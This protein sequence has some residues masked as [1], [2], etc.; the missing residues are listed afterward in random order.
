[1]SGDVPTGPMTRFGSVRRKYIWNILK[2]GPTEVGY[3]YFRARRRRKNKADDETKL[4][5]SDRLMFSGQFDA[6]ADELTANAALIAA[7]RHSERHE[8]RRIVW[9]LPYFGHAYFGGTYTLLRFAER[10][11]TEHG[12]AT[13]FHCYDV[14]HDKLGELRGRLSEA[15]PNLSGSTF[16][17]GHD[18]LDSIPASDAAIATLWS[19]AYPLVR[20]RSTRAKFYFVQD[21][22]PQFYPA[23]AASGLVEQSYRLGIPGI[24]NTPGLADV[25][26]SYGNP[27]VS[28]VPAV[29]LHRY[30]PAET[31]HD[32]AAPLRVF[33]YGRPSTPRNSFSLGIMAMAGLKERH[34]DRVDLIC[35]GENW[36]P[37]A[38]GVAGR[39]R[40]LGVLGNLDEVAALYRSCDIGLVFMQT[41]HPSYQPLEFMA[42]GVATV[43]N[44]NPATTWLLRHEQN[45]LLTEPLP[46]PAIEQL[47]RLVTDEPLRQ[48][49]VK[50]GL[51]EVRRHHWEDQ[52]DRIWRAMTLQDGGFRA[53]SAT[54]SATA[55]RRSA[56]PAG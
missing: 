22:E 13:H 25:Y 32:P 31:P 38:F 52:I 19:G 23:G 46:S 24:V 29:D 40:N 41:K 4:T 30:H 16:T 1:M 28:F 14:G 11:A 8:I 18:P 17:C 56:A 49:I 37:G 47:S 26:R 39:I 27:A 35:A 34:G 44:H 2:Q 3:A 54:E 50:N 5:E 7:Y 55:L 33:F 21:Y 42:S 45:C 43:S 48:R 53:D 15:F 9:M 20:L 12:V 10:F 36:N 6:T 51:V